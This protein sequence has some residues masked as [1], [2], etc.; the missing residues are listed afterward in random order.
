MTYKKNDKATG[1]AYHL[2]YDGCTGV[3]L[4]DDPQLLDVALV[5]RNGM[6]ALK[7]H[8]LAELLPRVGAPAGTEH[9]VSAGRQLLPLTGHANLEPGDV[10]GIAVAPIDAHPT[11]DMCH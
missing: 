9:F 8:Y 6:P 2:K 5:R 7:G 1:A 3:T 11:R 10:I 4:S